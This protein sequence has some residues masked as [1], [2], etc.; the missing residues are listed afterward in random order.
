MV[1]DFPVKLRML[2][3]VMGCLVMESLVMELM[4]DLTRDWACDW[5]RVMKK[6]SEILM[7]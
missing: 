1:K 5:V 4:I 2:N 7:Y 3:S 6:M